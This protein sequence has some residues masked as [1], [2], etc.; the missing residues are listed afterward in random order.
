M[1]LLYPLL[2]KL[3]ARRPRLLFVCSL[4]LTLFF[5]TGIYLT[6]FKITVFP[7]LLRPYAWLL[8]PTWLFYFTAGMYLTKERLAAIAEKAGK[9]R[10]VLS[11]AAVACALLFAFEGKATG[12]FELS[13]RPQAI[14]LTLA[15]FLAFVGVLSRFKR[16]PALDSA[17]S[18]LSRRSSTVY[19]AHVLILRLLADR[20]TI[21]KGVSGMA[22]LY[23]CVAALSI[24][25]ATVI[26]GLAG[27]VRLRKTSI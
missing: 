20:L 2:K 7:G 10:L 19:F 18:F 26:D 24:T 22:L 8:F 16:A 15:A 12:S 11:A 5:Q 3:Q 23:L 6:C 14:L 25:A 1:Y 9:K 17:A 4:L 13:I 27:K 21:F